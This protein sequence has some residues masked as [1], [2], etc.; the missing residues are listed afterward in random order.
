MM[1]YL[2]MNASND[3]SEPIAYVE[4]EVSCPFCEESNWLSISFDDGGAHYICGKCSEEWMV[5]KE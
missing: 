4:Y 1:A 2:E 5:V 3:I